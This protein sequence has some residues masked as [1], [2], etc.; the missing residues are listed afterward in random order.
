[1]PNNGAITQ[2]LNAQLNKYSIRCLW[3]KPN[4]QRPISEEE[5]DMATI[6]EL[7]MHSVI[8]HHVALWVSLSNTNR[9][10]SHFLYK[11]HLVCM[12]N[13]KS[14]DQSIV[15]F[16]EPQYWTGQYQAARDR[17]SYYWTVK[18]QRN[19]F[20]IPLLSPLQSAESPR[21]PQSTD[22]SPNQVWSF[23]LFKI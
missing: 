11:C 16:K 5:N 20:N 21:L 23:F 6:N 8:Y 18:K 22:F 2:E 4:K 14:Y 15:P 13:Y 1:M 10:L 19:H 12:A 7:N 17:V 3:I 9:C